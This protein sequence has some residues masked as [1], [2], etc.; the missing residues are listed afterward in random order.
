VLPWTTKILTNIFHMHRL[1]GLY[2]PKS[3]GYNKNE[4]PFRL[5]KIKFHKQYLYY[6]N[7]NS[8]PMYHGSNNFIA[9]DNHKDCAPYPKYKVSK[10]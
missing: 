2:I 1:E 4:K 9:L 7:Y 6:F 10:T 5:P 8:V 3:I